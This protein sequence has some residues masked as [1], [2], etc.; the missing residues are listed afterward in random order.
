MLRLIQLAIGCVDCG[1]NGD[2]RILEWDHVPER[3]DK[4]SSPSTLAKR[5][6]AVLMTEVE[7]CDVVCAN[8]HSIRTHERRQY[9]HQE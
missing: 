3:G 8:C 4:V 1:V 5:S 7:K 2:W 6:F 9:A